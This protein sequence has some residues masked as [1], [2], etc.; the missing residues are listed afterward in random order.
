MVGLAYAAPLPLAPHGAEDE[1]DAA[2]KLGEPASESVDWSTNTF[3]G[4]TG[5]PGGS[6]SRIKVVLQGWKVREGRVRI[7]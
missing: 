4:I 6:T 7:R 1:S 3:G 5:N 2:F